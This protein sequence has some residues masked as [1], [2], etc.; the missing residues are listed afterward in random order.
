MTAR[1]AAAK[2]N[3]R[4]GCSS[5]KKYGRLCSEQT[6]PVSLTKQCRFPRINDL[7]TDRV[8]AYAGDFIII[9]CTRC[10][11]PKQFLVETSFECFEGGEL[12]ALVEDWDEDSKEVRARPQL[13]SDGPNEASGA[14]YIFGLDNVCTIDNHVIRLLQSHAFTGFIFTSTTWICPFLTSWMASRRKDSNLSSYEWDASKDPKM[15]LY[16]AKFLETLPC[17]ISRFDVIK[18]TAD[19]MLQLKFISDV[20][21][22][23]IK[24]V[25][26]S[27]RDFEFLVLQYI[28]EVSSPN[29]KHVSIIFLSNWRT[30]MSKSGHDDWNEYLIANLWY[31]DRFDFE[32]LMFQ[33][34]S[35]TVT[36]DSISE[37]KAAYL[38]H[39]VLVGHCVLVR[40]YCLNFVFSSP[41][42]LERLCLE[43]LN[44][45]VATTTKLPSLFGCTKKC[46]MLVRWC[47]ATEIAL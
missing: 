15:K 47:R 46:H 32:D 30:I 19:A 3:S 35:A 26:E 33:L 18:T 34:A 40:K 6:S 14:V 20:E 28:P 7:T 9:N 24:L 1:G 12:A 17:C 16:K 29:F 44:L 31:F 41:G 8:I 39:E 43:T 25:D 36:I 38:M 22:E 4:Q 21:L 11:L 27:R 45:N 10:T 23:M 37:L 2:R 5:R 13:S 42:C